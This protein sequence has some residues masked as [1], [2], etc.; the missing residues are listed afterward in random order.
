LPAT[1]LAIR[2]PEPGIGSAELR[3]G[4]VSESRAK[5]AANTVARSVVRSSLAPPPNAAWSGSP[6]PRAARLSASPHRRANLSEVAQTSSAGL[7]PL[8]IPQ[9]AAQRLA[10]LGLGQHVPELDY[11]APFFAR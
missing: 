2:D 11:R 7:A 5:A 1:R 8:L 10:H 6:T 3:S 9:L 4:D